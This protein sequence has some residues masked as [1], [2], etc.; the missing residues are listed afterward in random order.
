[1]I[2]YLVFFLLIDLKTG[3]IPPSYGEEGVPPPER[4]I[5]LVAEAW[6][7]VEFLSEAKRITNA[8]NGSTK[9]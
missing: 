8:S 5:Q 3:E 6:R 4:T 1:M 2:I 7:A 9:A